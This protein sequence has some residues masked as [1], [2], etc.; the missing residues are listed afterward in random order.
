M[1]D[2]KRQAIL[3]YFKDWL[4][5]VTDTS[6]ELADLIRD[7]LKDGFM[8]EDIEEVLEDELDQCTDIFESAYQQLFN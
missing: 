3:G 7:C 6:N 2:G 8:L 5:K 1:T 4:E